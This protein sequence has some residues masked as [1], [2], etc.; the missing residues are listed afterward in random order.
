MYL[1]SFDVGIK[2]MAYCVFDLCGNQIVDWNILDCSSYDTIETK[3][4]GE[5]QK[6]GKNCEN[7]AKYYHGDM[8]VCEKHA[9]SS[10]RYFISTKEEKKISKKSLKELKELQSKYIPT[11]TSV[12]KKDIISNVST[13]LESH[14]WKKIEKGK[15]ASDIDLIEIGRVLY[16]KL[17]EIK[18][19]K[20]AKYVIIENQ[21]SPIANRMKTIQGMIAQHFISLGTE[22][23]EFVSSSNKL[24]DLVTKSNA[25][26]EYK[27]HKQDGIHYCREFLK[28][29]EDKWKEV[30]EN[31]KKK[32]DLADCFLQGLWYKN[33]ILVKND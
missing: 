12:L 22:R 19:M 25:T 4:C 5:I 24:K 14:S 15:K 21:I 31:S 23:I 27:K 17:N 13:Y 7:I 3:K 30:L 6:N 29:Y 11:D 8:Y 33:V 18:Y 32:D 10:N 28:E 16:R 9:K 2:N 26:T 20:D 1:V